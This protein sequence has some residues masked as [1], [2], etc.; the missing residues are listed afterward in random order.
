MVELTDDVWVKLQIEFKRG[1]RPVFNPVPVA[2]WPAYISLVSAQRL[3]TDTGAGDT[4]ERVV[5]PF[6][7]PEW[8]QWA[9]E[10]LG[11]FAPSATCNN[12]ASW[13]PIWNQQY[14][15]S[16]LTIQAPEVK[17]E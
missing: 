11:V 16:L 8:R 2:D 12:C 6:G 3:P 13:K 7:S 1:H 14:P 17:S 15:Y 4:V 9:K 5:G 10:A